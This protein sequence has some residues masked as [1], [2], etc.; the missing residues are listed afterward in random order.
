MEPIFLLQEENVTERK[1]ILKMTTCSS[2]V[3][4]PQWRMHFKVLST[5][6]NGIHSSVVDTRVTFL[7]VCLSV[8]TLGI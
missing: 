8:L 3:N 2:S 4:S 5:T 1:F 7:P 6:E